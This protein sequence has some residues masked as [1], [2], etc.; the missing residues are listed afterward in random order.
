LRDAR[1]KATAIAP[2]EIATMRSHERRSIRR[3][4]GGSSTC[5]LLLFTYI[6]LRRESERNRFGE[7]PAG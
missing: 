6:R 3:R 5:Y 2:I 7:D 4:L 1:N